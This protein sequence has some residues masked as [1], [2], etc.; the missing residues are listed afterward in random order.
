MSDFEVI[1]DLLLVNN[2]IKNWCDVMATKM[3]DIVKDDRLIGCGR[4]LK[5]YKMLEKINDEIIEVYLNKYNGNKS[6]ERYEK[7][8][9]K[10]VEKRLDDI[11]EDYI[12]NCLINDLIKNSS[13]IP[14][15]QKFGYTIIPATFKNDDFVPMK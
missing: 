4:D 15:Y 5:F 13:I 1:V 8:L 2:V 7:R 14:V 12:S 11:L 10:A 3:L 6:M 9:T